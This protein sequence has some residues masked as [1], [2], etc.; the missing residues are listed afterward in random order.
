MSDNSFLQSI[1]K[2]S[3]LF[4]KADIRAHYNNHVSLPKG[5]VEQL[6]H[7]SY[8]EQWEIYN[9]NHWYHIKLEDQS[10]ILFKKD[11]FKYIMTPFAKMESKSLYEDKF[12]QELFDEGYNDIEIDELCEDIEMIYQNY[13]D[14]ELKIGSHTPI[15]FDYHPMQYN[16]VNHPVSHLHIGHEN[17]SRIPIKKIMT[18]YA[19]SG[20]ILAT[21]YPDHWKRIRIENKISEID[22]NLMNKSLSTVQEKHTDKWCPDEEENRFFMV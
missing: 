13:L 5:Y 4:S 21:F 17:D 12:K 18:P 1:A 6:R 8:R 14:T 7:N 15:R 2:A 16:N 11:S 22:Y 10:L 3:A 9:K 19:F 20:F